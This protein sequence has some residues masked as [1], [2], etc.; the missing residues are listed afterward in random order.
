MYFGLLDECDWFKQ[1]DVSADVLEG[2]GVYLKKSKQVDHT[3][4]G[5]NVMVTLTQKVKVQRMD[6]SLELMF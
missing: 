3:K 1:T 6:S 2:K 4:D 5:F